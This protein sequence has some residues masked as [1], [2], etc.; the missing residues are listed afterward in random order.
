LDKQAEVT[1]GDPVAC[2]AQGGIKEYWELNN[3]E[4][5]DGL[6]GLIS[7]QKSSFSLAGY[8]SNVDVEPL[9]SIASQATGSTLSHLADIKNFIIGVLVCALAASLY[10]RFW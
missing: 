2:R 10:S 8:G 7:A 5:L 9:T 3:T 1:A 6:T 4:S